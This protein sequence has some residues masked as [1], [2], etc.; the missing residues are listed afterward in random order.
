MSTSATEPSDSQAVPVP[1]TPRLALLLELQEVDLA[2]D[3][4]AYKRRELA[5]RVA[6]TELGARLAELTARVGEAE[7]QR[8]KLVSQQLTLDQRSESVGGRIATIEQRLRS[9]RAGSYRDEQAMG[10]EVASLTHLRR[11]IEDQELEI[12]E[13]LEPLD[14]ELTGLKESS[15]SVAEELAL[16]REQLALATAEIDDEAAIVRTARDQLAERVAPEL[17]ASY[18]RLRAKLGGIGAAHVVGGACSGCHLQL[19]AGE[20]HRLRQAMPD[21][22]VH[23]DQCGRILVMTSDQAGR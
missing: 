20:L 1:S 4:L 10:D 9:G 16:A 3:R 17:T 23:C 15:S 19:P 18:E 5:E 12:M 2:L 11:E 7:E 8:E 14:Q 21:S 6:V 13:A 22:V